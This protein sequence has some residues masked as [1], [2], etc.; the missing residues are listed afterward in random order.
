M[1]NIACVTDEMLQSLKPINIFGYS[2]YQT[3]TVPNPNITVPNR[4]NSSG[5]GTTLPGLLS[6]P[7]PLL[8]GRQDESEWQGLFQIV[9]SWLGEESLRL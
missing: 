6:P 4:A 3:I 9:P 5:T 1:L 8:T 7:K 2:S